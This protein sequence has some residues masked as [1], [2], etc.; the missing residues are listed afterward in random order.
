[1]RDWGFGLSLDDFGTG[2]SSLSYLRELPFDELKIDKS[3]LDSLDR[4]SSAKGILRALV[5]L[6]NELR[7]SVVAEGVESQD[8]WSFL[9]ACGC[10]K[11]QGY[12]LSRPL[13]GELALE[14]LA[15]PVMPGIHG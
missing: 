14:F 1:M 6:A 11:I 2:Y 15:L 8:Q 9:R 10:H 12:L 5:A 7:L 13:R 3:F 4:D